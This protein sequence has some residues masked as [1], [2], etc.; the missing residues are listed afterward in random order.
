MPQAFSVTK[1]YI[2]SKIKINWQVAL[3]SALQSL[4][5]WVDEPNQVHF[6]LLSV[7]KNFTRGNYNTVKVIDGCIE[8]KKGAKYVVLRFSERI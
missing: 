5:R 3:E 8:G 4:F 6:L 1:N 7:R 2:Y